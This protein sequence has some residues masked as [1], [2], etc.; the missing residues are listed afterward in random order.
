MHLL[1]CTTFVNISVPSFSHHLSLK[2]K[3]K[4]TINACHVYL[5]FHTIQTIAF[6]VARKWPLPIFAS[7]KQENTI[8]FGVDN[9]QEEIWGS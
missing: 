7:I 6:F 5:K 8:L 3:E 4:P 9:P 1:D 2:L